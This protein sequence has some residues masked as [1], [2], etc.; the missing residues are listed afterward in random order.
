MEKYN[1]PEG[2]RQMMLPLSQPNAPQLFTLSILKGAAA[3][4]HRCPRPAAAANVCHI[5]YPF[6][7]Q[8]LSAK[9]KMK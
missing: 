6:R 2:L 8:Y 9:F 1:I 4:T 3:A 7:I 5:A